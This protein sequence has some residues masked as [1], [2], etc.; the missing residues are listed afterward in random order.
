MDLYLVLLLPM[1]GQQ[2]AMD[3]DLGG[4]IAFDLEAPELQLVPMLS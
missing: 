3:L 1:A 2:L 4:V